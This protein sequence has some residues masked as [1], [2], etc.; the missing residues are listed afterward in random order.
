M[1]GF[2]P[3]G[4]DVWLTGTLV[5]RVV[6]RRDGRPRHNQPVQVEGCGFG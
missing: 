4:E 3:F 2:L 6:G 5:V 1:D